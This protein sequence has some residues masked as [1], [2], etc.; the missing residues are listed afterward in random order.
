MEN[1]VNPT[2]SE[3]VD[4]S[5]DSAPKPKI[6]IALCPGFEGHECGQTFE[7]AYQRGRPRKWCVACV[8]LKKIQAE[9][10]KPIRQPLPAVGT[11]ERAEYQRNAI[12]KTPEKEKALKAE[13]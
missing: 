11:P 2:Q 10:Q 12:A 3:K 6:V 13:G 1:E 8:E 7:R 5:A 4:V 9:S